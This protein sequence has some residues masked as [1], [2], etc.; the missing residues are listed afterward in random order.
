MLKESAFALF[1][2][3]TAVSMDEKS[4]QEQRLTTGGKSK[5]KEKTAKILRRNVLEIIEAFSDPRDS[6]KMTMTDE[7]WSK[8]KVKGQLDLFPNESSIKVFLDVDTKE[9]SWK[10]PQNLIRRH[11]KKYIDLQLQLR[12]E[13]LCNALFDVC[14]NWYSAGEAKPFFKE[15]VVFA[16]K[17][18]CIDRRGKNDRTSLIL[19]T[20]YDAKEAAAKLVE[21]GANVEAFDGDGNTAL[22]WA[23]LYDSEEC[24]RILLQKGAVVNVRNKIGSTPLMRAKSTKITKLLLAFDANIKATNN[25][26]Q[27]ALEWTYKK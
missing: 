15:L 25:Y 10:D 4:F 23:A 13:E 14:V 21:R 26:G 27:T 1:L 12:G 11:T 5:E 19:A 17:N 6:I 2:V 7:Q 18:V 24:C 9:I 22:H 20:K 16:S 3:F 8:V